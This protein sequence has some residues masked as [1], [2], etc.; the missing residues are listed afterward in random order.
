MTRVGS[1]LV[2]IDIGT[3]GCKTTII[4]TKGGLVSS[5]SYEYPTYYP[6][7]S[8]AEQD[9][10]SWYSAL[11]NSVKN[12]ILKS[13]IKSR[14]IESICIDGQVHTPVFLNEN[15]DILRPS[16]PWTDQRSTAQ[17]ERLKKRVGQEKIIEITFN[18]P[19]N[20]FTLPQ[21]LWVKDNQPKIWKKI[22]KILIAKD[23][24]RGL[25]TEQLWCTDHSDATTTLLFDGNS[26]KWSEFL[27]SSAEIPLEKLP[28]I[29]PSSKIAG[30]INKNTSIETGLPEGVP[31][32]YGA[33]DC[34]VET[35]AAKTTYPG[36]CFV[37]L[38][39]SGVI[40]ITTEKPIPDVKGRTVTYCLPTTTT[41]TLWLT[42]TGTASC[43]SALKWFRDTF[44]SEEINMAEKMDTTAYTLFDD[45]AEKI[46]LGSEG[47]I[48]HPYLIGEL[49]PYLDPYLRGSFYGITMRHKKEHFYRAVLEGIAFSIRDSLHIFDEIGLPINDINLIGG[50][51]NSKVWRAILCDILGKNGL[52][53]VTSDA[54]FG[55]ALLAGL[56]I[57]VFKNLQDV[58]TKCTKINAITKY[59]KEKHEKYEKLFQIYKQI[60]DNLSETAYT[61]H[62]TLQELYPAYA[63]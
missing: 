47:L 40:S 26:F 46:P 4:N 50:G 49:S 53:P 32:V 9:P 61:L 16:I 10:A 57:H 20:S 58:V 59:D 21:I 15:W 35:L 51:S 3:G 19:A 63:L 60:H 13:D 14:E 55:S 38:A 22:Y 17:V 1:Y 28:E 5:A 41:P 24:I 33:S 12:A 27:C 39:T 34:S 8:F 31:V 23:Y 25:L 43:A 62:N 30:Y 18:P 37:K 54:S 44:G 29:M 6:K 52:K 45:M 2:G 7:P 48:F 42:K 11:T 56:G 36:E